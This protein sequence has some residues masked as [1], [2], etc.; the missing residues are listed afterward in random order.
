MVLSSA[1]SVTRPKVMLTP[2]AI[3]YGTK[4]MTSCGRCTV[5]CTS[6]ATAVSPMVLIT[7]AEV[8][9]AASTS[10][11]SGSRSSEIPNADTTMLAQ[12]A[13]AAA[14]ATLKLLLVQPV[15]R[16]YCTAVTATTRTSSTPT[17]GR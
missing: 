8:T 9:A 4:T 7:M 14:D 10:Q 15:F 2:V 3:A 5:L 17:G 11:V 12:A 6:A 1:S 16:V 13:P